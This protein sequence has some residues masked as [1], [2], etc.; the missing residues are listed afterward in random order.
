MYNLENKILE[1]N[2]NITKIIKATTKAVNK[3]INIEL[4]KIVEKIE[5]NE[6]LSEKDLIVLTQ[7]E[8]ILRLKKQRERINMEK[9]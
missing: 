2:T 8:Y 5:K 3:M 4:N 1:Q 7:I 9:I 6:S